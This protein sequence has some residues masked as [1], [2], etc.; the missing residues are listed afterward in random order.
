MPCTTSCLVFACCFLLSCLCLF[1]SSLVSLSS[2]FGAFILKPF[3]KVAK[4]EIPKSIPTDKLSDCF[5]LC[6]ASYSLLSICILKL[7]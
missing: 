6:V 5:V 4:L 2:G 3:D 1:A 7:A